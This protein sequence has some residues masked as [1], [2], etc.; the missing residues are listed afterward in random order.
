MRYAL[1]ALLFGLTMG[2]WGQYLLHVDTV[3]AMQP[4]LT[5]H[6]FS[7]IL[8]DSSDRVSAVYGNDEAT[9]AIQAPGGVYN[10][11]LNTTWNAS[12]INP[13]F[14]PIFPELADD[15]YA[16]VGLTGP[17]SLTSD[18][19]D[20]DPALLEDANEPISPFFLTNA[21]TS[22]QVSSF[23]GSSWYVLNT[24]S[25][26]LAGDD[27]KVLVMQITS[28]GPLTGSVPVQIFPQ[29]NGELELRMR[30][31]FDGIGEFEGVILSQDFI[32]GCT[33]QVA[34]NYDASASVDDGQCLYLDVCGVCGGMG[35]P[36]GACNCEGDVLD[37]C[38]ECGGAGEGCQGCTLPSACNYDPE[39][40]VNDGSCEYE[41]CVGCTNP[42]AC[43]YDPNATLN[44]EFLCEYADFGYDCFG[45]CL[46]D[47]D[48]DGVCDFEDDCVGVIDACGECNGPGDVFEC[49]CFPKPEGYCDCE[50]ELLDSD[51]DGVCDVDEVAGCTDA[52]ACN[53]SEDATDDN[54]T[55]K[56]CTCSTELELEA[57][58][59][60]EKSTL[61]G[62]ATEGI[63]NDEDD[64]MFDMRVFLPSDEYRVTR[65]FGNDVRPLSVS[66][67]GVV[68]NSTMPESYWP[69]E[70]D[71]E[72]DTY[73]TIGLPEE[74]FSDGGEQ[75]T[76]FG[77]SAG[78]SFFTG[79]P[80][81]SFLGLNTDVETGWEV[82]AEATNG[83]DTGS[84]VQLM[85]VRLTPIGN[86]VTKIYGWVSVE[87]LSLQDSSSQQL[88][89]YYDSHIGG[90]SSGTWIYTPVYGRAECVCGD[91][92]A[93]N[94]NPAGAYDTNLCTYGCAGCTDDSACNYD[95][96]ATV[97]DGSFCEYPD[98]GADCFGECLDD[99]DED[100]VC[101]LVDDCVG[102]Y[103]ECGVCNGPG[104]VYEC[105]CSV[106]PA[107]DCDCEG[108]QID[109]LGVCGGNCH[110]DSDGDG[111][112]DVD[113]LCIE[114]SACNYDDPENEVCL[115]EDVVG[116]CG[117][118]CEA[119]ANQNGLCDSDECNLS[120]ADYAIEGGPLL[121][122]ACFDGCPTCFISELNI[123][124][125]LSGCSLADAAVGIESFYVNMEHSFGGDLD[126]RF[127]CPNGQELQVM[128][129][130]GPIFNL[131]VPNYSDDPVEPGE[132]WNYWWSEG[133]QLDTWSNEAAG[134]VNNAYTLPSGVYASE[135][136][137]TA[138][139]GC[140]LN[141]T[142]KL[143]ICD[144]WG[145]DNGYLFEWGIDFSDNLWT[146]VACEEVQAAGPESCG[147]GTY[148]NE[149]SAA[150][151]LAVPPFLGE[152]GDYSTINPCYFDLDLSGVVGSGD[153]LNFLGTYGME[154]GCSWTPE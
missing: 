47:E 54:G 67:F 9:L 53:Y 105:G 88:S 28:S 40:A 75:P 84:G 113:D 13:A 51:G 8:A 59:G 97:D 150:C 34:C 24:A 101:D 144:N 91:M 77:D 22:L 147:W 109:V 16:T 108:T 64:L 56:F 100:G 4:G 48:G 116:V 93:C 131:G 49:G 102:A 132:G 123:D 63:Y 12:G 92:L 11:T 7:V 153:L 149:D 133:A 72:P 27:M 142:W 6:R 29:G 107:G 134:L 141:G 110:E 103:D 55:C 61:A 154:A 39:A 104:A 46:E 10:S 50:G 115:V 106:I 26:G 152:F 44:N 145:W 111:I 120:G 78:M 130:P 135:T 73:A 96:E 122:A 95:P 79:D 125:F 32:S 139:D 99:V 82:P 146:G 117:G 89:F 126:I 83:K 42:E 38:G 60:I 90:V 21:A 69:V 98:L 80:F 85:A 23:L 151:V 86:V 129:Y 19:L 81:V 36:E 114:L 76:F 112:C 140:P 71:E 5:V 143:E 25:N 18:P 138:L 65:V 3:P 148:W 136:P 20:Q 15:S 33:D 17:A 41:S 74:V 30:F 31:D 118:G 14:L 57:Y 127:I 45:A 119:D 137:W 37:P 70:G 62:T 52:L 66:T 68:R 94:Y 2:V 121:D 43:T 124:N 1:L 87:V 35:I 128:S 58:L